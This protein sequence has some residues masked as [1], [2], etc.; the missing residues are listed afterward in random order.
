M[1]RPRRKIMLISTEVVGDNRDIPG[2]EHLEGDN[3][4][5]V[6]QGSL[7]EGEEPLLAGILV[8]EQHLEDIP[9]EE[10]HR[11]VGSNLAEGKQVPGQGNQAV[12]GGCHTH[13][14]CS[15]QAWVCKVGKA[16]AYHQVLQGMGGDQ[17]L[18][19][20][21]WELQL[22][23]VLAQQGQYCQYWTHWEEVGGL[24]GHSYEVVV[25]G[26]DE[27]GLQGEGPATYWT[28]RRKDPSIAPLSL[29]F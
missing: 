26:H 24:V 18:L 5:V 29:S 14:G 21:D 6:H 17:V 10:L 11:E 1:L 13:T 8:E 28:G 9:V 15:L 4:V 20:K 16:W 12:L 27:L 3:P 7:A 2:E 25:Q 22:A 19:H 23:V